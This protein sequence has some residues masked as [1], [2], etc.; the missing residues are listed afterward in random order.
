MPVEATLLK[1][2]GGTDNFIT[3]KYADQ[4][5]AILNEW[6]A[7]LR[8]T[9][10]ETAAIEKALSDNFSGYSLAATESRLTRPRPSLEVRHNKFANQTALRR[11]AFLQSAKSAMSS[12]RKS[13]PPNS[14]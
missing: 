10:T 6:S 14:K 5:A 9:P 2:K 4:I 13:Q 11:D 1:A 3:E 7:D 8:Q 12:F